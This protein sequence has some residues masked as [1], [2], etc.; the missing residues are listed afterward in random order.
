MGKMTKSLGISL[1]FAAILIT[2]YTVPTIAQSTTKPA[3]PEFTVELSG[4]AF[5]T[6]PTYTFNAGTG[7]F[8]PQEGYHIPYSTL[9]IIIKNQPFTTQTNYD[10]LCYNVRIKPHNYPD[11]YWQELFHAESDGY[12]L[13]AS[14]D[15]TI[16]PLPIEGS[17]VLGTVI[18][19]GESTDVQVEAM[20]GYI[21]RNQTYPYEYIFYGETSG[22]SSTQTVT[23]PPKTPFLTSPSSTPFYTQTPT[24][25]GTSDGLV[26]VPLTIFLVTV[27]VLFSLVVTLSVMLLH[28]G[29]TKR[30]F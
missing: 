8:D 30:T 12:P 17:Q 14:G 20:I 6:P 5:D 1:L 2:A 3:T 27:T 4:P 25:T 11:S 18:P 23:V 24:P 7:L 13:Q 29:K 9:K 22:W 26:M 15:H 16:I 21:G 10:F 19:T 28:R